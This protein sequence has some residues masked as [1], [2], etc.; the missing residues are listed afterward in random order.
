M[1]QGL[2][3]HAFNAWRTGLIPGQEN[4]IPHAHGVAKKKKKERERDRRRIR[5]KLGCCMLRVRQTSSTS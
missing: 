2:R 4:K 3:L 1:A 5:R